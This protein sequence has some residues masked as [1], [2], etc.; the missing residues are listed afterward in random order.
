MINAMT[1]MTHDAFYALRA[2]R[3]DLG[4]VIFATLIIGLGIG[5]S[6]AIFSIMSP[7]MLRPLPFDEP[8]NLVWIANTGSSGMSAVTSRTSNL[9][10]FRASSESFDGLTGYYA[11]FQNRSYNLW[12]EGE[13]ERLAGVDVAQN[14][15]E[16]LGVEP[17]IGRN[18]V[19]EEGVWGGRSAVILSHALWTRRFGAD[20]AIVSS[21]I[22][23][24]NV[25]YEVVGVLPPSF[26]FASI[27]APQTRVDFLTTFPISDETDRRGNTL[28]MIGRLKPGITVESAQAE[29]DR[30]IEGLQEADPDR[31]GLGAVVTDLQAKIAGPFRSGLLLL[32]A[33][34]A[35]V[36]LIVCVNLSNLLL[37]K[38][39]KRGQEMAVRSALGA[40][41]GRLLRQLLLES[42]LLALGG[43]AVGVPLAVVVTRIAARSHSISIPMLGSVSVDGRALLFSLLSAVVAGLVVGIVPALQISKG[44]EAAAFQGA[45]RGIGGSRRSTRLR[46]SLVVAEVALACILLVF[47]GLLLKSFQRVLDVELGFQPAGSVAWQVRASRDF[48]TLEE[49]NAYYEQLVANVQSVPG[50][51]AVG[52]TDALPLGRNRG[53]SLSVPGIQYED[54]VERLIAFPHV[55]D[56]RY[57]STMQ[58]PLVAGRHFTPHDTRE[59][60]NV[61]ILNETAAKAVMLGEEVLGREVLVSGEKA[62]VVGIVADVRHRSLEQEAGREMYLPFTQSGDFGTLDMVVRSRLPTASLVESVAAAMR[63]ADPALPTGEY[64]TLEAVVERSVSPRRFTLLLLTA[65]AGTALILAALGIYGVLSYS[66]AERLPEI[67]VR[68]ALGES[69]TSILKRVVGKTL[70]LAAIGVALGA[71]GSSFASKTLAAMLFGVPPTDPLIFFAMAMIL[72]LV[73]M[74]AGFVPA[75]RAARTD[76]VVALQST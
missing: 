20:P 41:R 15:L 3:K 36:M 16:V 44:G 10:D 27:F 39:P 66:V 23:L 45:G 51:E 54:G 35:A 22:S 74:V 55:I 30:I 67:G 2:V 8:Q 64:Q 69:G 11:F 52:L 17:L 53:W 47:G 71:L 43:A 34:A 38:G 6:T 61:V 57:I 68:M 42:L 76:P 14:F 63:A 31:W 75:L 25:P 24:N 29:L 5:A 70:A 19:E 37:S 60:A 13:P 1:E 9:R 62:E 28:S 40:P 33:A 46:E 56:H 4:L 72:L 7:M 73:A 21:S 58:I 59:T 32:A 18:F 26:D 12:G 49:A 50:V 65:F 48:E